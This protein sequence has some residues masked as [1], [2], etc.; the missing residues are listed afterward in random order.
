MVMYWIFELSVWKEWLDLSCG[1]V[2]RM[3]RRA[4]RNIM[5]STTRSPFTV[6]GSGCVWH[7]TMN[8]AII[9]SGTL[10]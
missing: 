6:G 4:I 1:I 3:C 2:A 7:N 10:D 9:K 5:Q 8:F